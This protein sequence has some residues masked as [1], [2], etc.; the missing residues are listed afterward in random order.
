VESN[1]PHER[2]PYAI[3]EADDPIGATLRQLEYS[4]RPLAEC[5]TTALSDA[6][7][8]QVRA[9]IEQFI[10]QPHPD[11][12]R[13]GPVCPFAKLAYDAES[14]YASSI[15]ATP[16]AFEQLVELA[17]RL[18]AT[19]KQI[20]AAHNLSPLLFALIVVLPEMAPEKYAQFV[21]LTQAIAKPVFMR[22]GLMIGEFHPASRV[23]G[24]HSPNFHPM[25]SAVPAFVI[26]AIAPHDVLFIDRPN[27]PVAFRINEIESLLAATRVPAEKA[28]A[29]RQRLKALKAPG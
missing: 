4:A 24:I 25:T 7:H 16:L 8:A 20:M 1:A 26:R 14:I 29:L 9:W 27:S 13:S 12:G 6:V 3:S 28:R 2:E 23:P 5:N 22:A 18:P 21:D 10:M 11:L 17:V 19:Y 15:A